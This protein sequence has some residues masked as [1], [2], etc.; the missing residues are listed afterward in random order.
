VFVEDAGEGVPDHL[1]AHLFE[2]FTRGD[3]ASG[4]GLGL[5]IARAYANA[6]GGDLVYIPT[7]GGARFA[8]SLV[9]PGPA[10]QQ[11]GSSL[12]VSTS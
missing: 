6:Q 1:R 4:T 10:A 9:S 12:P 7:S 2:R 3:D 8:L 11:T 5:A